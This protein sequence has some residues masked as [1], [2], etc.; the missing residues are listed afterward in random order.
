MPV[1]IYENPTTGER[2]E[3][4]QSMLEKH[5]YSENGTEWRRVWDIPKANTY[6]VNS[7]D[8]WSNAAFIEKTR[9]S[10]GS[11]GDLWDMSAELSARRAKSRGGV[12]PI[13][14]QAIKDYKKKCGGKDHPQAI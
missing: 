13:K 3:I 10:K 7:M 4:V 9:H 6:S 11:V 1:Y 2:K 12:D 5:V 14:Q 8:P